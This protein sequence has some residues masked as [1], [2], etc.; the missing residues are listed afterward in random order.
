[1]T[2][3]KAKTVLVVDDEPD[4]LDQQRIRLESAGYKVITAES[5]E[6]AEKL[7]AEVQPDI[8]LVDLMLEHADGG[9]ALCY[10]IKKRY[11]AI[12]VILITAVTSDTGL[13]FDAATDEERG[14]IKADAFL[15]KPIRYEQLQREM[16][17]LLGQQP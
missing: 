1:M 2:D 8:A 9:F 11:P 14:W 13:E 7:L 3:E 10:H 5:Q 16:D 4:F 17:K 6:Q 15:A 12:P